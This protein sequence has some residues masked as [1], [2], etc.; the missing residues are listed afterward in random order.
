M[1]CINARESERSIVNFKL[2]ILQQSLKEKFE[3]T[4]VILKIFAKNSVL[5]F[6]TLFSVVICSPVSH[7]TQPSEVQINENQPI[8]KSVTGDNNVEALSSS[9]V[10][11]N[12]QEREIPPVT[13]PVDFRRRYDYFFSDIQ[14]ARKKE[15]RISDSNLNNFATA[16]KSQNRTISKSNFTKDT[17]SEDDSV[18]ISESNV[19]EKVANVDNNKGKLKIIAI[20]NTYTLVHE[21]FDNNEKEVLLK[22]D[23][24]DPKYSVKMNI[25]KI[26]STEEEINK[27]LMNNN[28]NNNTDDFRD[29]PVALEDKRVLSATELLPIVSN[30]FLNKTLQKSFSLEDDSKA[31]NGQE[32]N[33]NTNEKDFNEPNENSKTNSTNNS[34]IQTREVDND[35]FFILVDSEPSSRKVKKDNIEPSKTDENGYRIDVITSSS[36][37]TYKQFDPLKN[38]SLDSQHVGNNSPLENTGSGNIDRQNAINIKQ[39]QGSASENSSSHVSNVAKKL[40]VSTSNTMER[41]SENT[42]LTKGQAVTS[43]PSQTSVV[44]PIRTNSNSSLPEVTLPSS[45]HHTKLDHAALEKIHSLASPVATDSVGRSPLAMFPED[46]FPSSS[47]FEELHTPSVQQERLSIHVSERVSSSISVGYVIAIVS[48]ILISMVIIGG[49]VAYFLYRR[50]EGFRPKILSSDRSCANSDSGGYLDDQC[51]VAYVNSQID[52]PKNTPEDLVSLDNDSFLNSLESMTIQN[53]WTDTI[54]HTKL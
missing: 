22:T 32:E 31:E 7:S 23:E 37:V 3:K 20:N 1:L 52:L 26:L 39:V 40:N 11:H 9:S 38:T 45:H 16:E 15:N 54:R 51:R 25:D 36:E 4:K 29:K 33:S 43:L 5:V 49:A 12:K 47:S 48:A 18:R 2:L 41:S 28:N 42:N 6:L 34:N 19:D 10:I 35:S 44:E 21:K 13:T 50:L 46:T 53:L 30:K 27:D 24:T 17:L 8:T 14:K